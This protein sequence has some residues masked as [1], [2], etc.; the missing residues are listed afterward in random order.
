MRT[1]ILGVGAQKSGTTWLSKQ[2][3]NAQ[4]YVPGLMKEYHIFDTLHLGEKHHED[5]KILKKLKN[6][7]QDIDEKEF[8]RRSQIVNSFYSN[9][10]NYYDF[11]DELLLKEYSFTA[12]ITPSYAGLSSDVFLEIKKQFE[13]RDIKVKVIF[14]MREPITRIESAVK[15]GLRRESILRQVDSAFVLD[16]ISEQLNS[17]ADML[18]ANYPVVC[19]QLENAFPTGDIFYGF[20]ETLF[21]AHEQARLAHFLGLIPQVFDT[22]KRINSTPKLFSY[23]TKDIENLKVRVEDRYQFVADKFNFDLSI[24]DHELYKLCN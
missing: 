3:N 2:L 8:H 14:F 6:F 12:D 11:F 5:T 19:Q 13:L 24:W 21:S 15:M 10:Q 23:T 9:T 4:N 18:R 22:S 16:K 1:F 17:P 20:Y 7:S